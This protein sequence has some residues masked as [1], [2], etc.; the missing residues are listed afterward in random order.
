[1]E[2]I[3]NNLTEC[4]TFWPSFL[5]CHESLDKGDFMTSMMLLDFKDWNC[6]FV[7]SSLASLTVSSHHCNEPRHLKTRN[8]VLSMIRMLV[9]DVTNQHPVGFSRCRIDAVS[10]GS[11]IRTGT[12]AQ[13]SASSSYVNFPILLRRTLKWSCLSR[14][15]SFFFF[16]RRQKTQSQKREN[17]FSSLRVESTQRLFIQPTFIL[18]SQNAH[19]NNTHNCKYL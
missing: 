1:M 2:L 15:L 8:L 16:F 5:F 14:F 10:Y 18:L 17:R 9:S 13:N 3:H 4:L 11:F 7:A 6:F 19:Y 12:T